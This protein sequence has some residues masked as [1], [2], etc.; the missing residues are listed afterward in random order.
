M[1]LLNNKIIKSKKVLY[2]GVLDLIIIDKVRVGELNVNKENDCRF[3]DE[4]IKEVIEFVEIKKNEI[5]EEVK[6]NV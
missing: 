5:L 1:I 2:K 3:R 4:V 6:M